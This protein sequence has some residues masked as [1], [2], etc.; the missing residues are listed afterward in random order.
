MLSFFV[1]TIALGEFMAEEMINQ[2]TSETEE[3]GSLDNMFV[4]ESDTSETEEATDETNNEQS[5]QEEAQ[6]FLSIRYNGEDKA[7]THDQAV[8]LAQKGM[9]YDKVKGNYDSLNQKFAALNSIAN[10]AG[11]TADEYLN[12]LNDFQEQSEI[13]EIANEYQQKHPDVD[14]EAAAEYANAVYQNKREAQAKKNEQDAKNREKQEN[15]YYRHQ[16]EQLFNYN[17]NIEIDK[18]DVEV[19]DDI[20]AGLSPLEAYLRWENKSLKNKATNNAINSKNKKN[21]NSLNANS[22]SAGG[23]PFL[24]GLLGK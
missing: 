11:M 1:P 13:T 19:I 9:N 22:S 10:R 23:D 21:A 24:E 20:N 17:P 8:M 15:D 7:L 2:S 14:D 16:V 18:L 3:T 5:E 6:D 4:D 12:R